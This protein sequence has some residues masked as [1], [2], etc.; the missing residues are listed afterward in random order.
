MIGLSDNWFL[1]PVFDFEYKSYQVLGYSQSLNSHFVGMRF[2][3]YID[4]LTLHLKRLRQY[5]SAKDE[6]EAK[7]HRDIQEIDFENKKIIKKPV[8]DSNGLITEIQE[9]LLFACNHFDSSLK[10]ASNELASL[11]K[12]I[13]IQ[14][15]GVSDLNLN[16]GIL[17]FRRPTFTRV[18]N[19]TLRLIRRPGVAHAYKDLKTNYIQ[20]VSTGSFTNFNE[21]KWN[22]LRAVGKDSGSNAFLIE[23]NRDFPHYELVMPLVKKHLINLSR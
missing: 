11:T 19:Y 3:P 18:Y 7:L 23:T 10:Y 22:I 1:E 13:E 21:I 17:L 16:R 12:E 15:L 9:I 5:V 4:D 6:L 20:D 2:Y 8:D 14:Q